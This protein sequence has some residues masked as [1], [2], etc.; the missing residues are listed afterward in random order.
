MGTLIE[1]ACAGRGWL[2][3]PI[4][5]AKRERCGRMRRAGLV[6]SVVSGV[7]AVRGMPAWVHAQG[8]DC[9]HGCVRGE[10]GAGRP[11]V[12]KKAPAPSA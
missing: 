10:D 11:D 3:A 8:G 4:E 6:G 12:H 1:R 7:R 5:R 2:G 9:R